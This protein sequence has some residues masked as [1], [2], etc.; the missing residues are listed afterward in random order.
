M[1]N[2][3]YLLIKI[4]KQ[5]RYELNQKLQ[6]QDI[7]IQQ[8]SVI[9]QINLWITIHQTGPTA[10]ALCQILDMDKPTMSGIIQRLVKKKLIYKEP[11]PN[12]QR[13]QLLGLTAIGETALTAGEQTSDQLLNQYLTVLTPDEQK[14]LQELLIKLNGEIKS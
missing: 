12:D 9:Q 4:T 8:W 5:L 1:N 11:N 2:I 3:G 7:T 10:N 13:S 6:S 14:K